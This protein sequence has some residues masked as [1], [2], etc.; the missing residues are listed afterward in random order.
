MG[1]GPPS[2]PHQSLPIKGTDTATSSPCK[3]VPKCG[4]SYEEGGEALTCGDPSSYQTDDP[5]TWRRGVSASR[6]SM[7]GPQITAPITAPDVVS[8]V[9]AFQMHE[10]SS[11]SSQGEGEVNTPTLQM[12]KPRLRQG[13]DHAVNWWQRGTRK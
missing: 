4:S 7:L 3:G 11:Q 6:D 1:Q 2:I 9:P 5:A 13:K 12:R 10:W 8:S